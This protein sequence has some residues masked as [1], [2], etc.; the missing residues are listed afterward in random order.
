MRKER[1]K[2]W[3]EGNAYLI[4]SGVGGGPLISRAESRGTQP[5]LG[6]LVLEGRE[7]EK[8]CYLNVTYDLLF[9][10]RCKIIYDIKNQP[11]A[12]WCL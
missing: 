5:T 4:T 10:S 9:A 7:R 6:G 8:I 11:F 2:R 1:R 3:S 12:L